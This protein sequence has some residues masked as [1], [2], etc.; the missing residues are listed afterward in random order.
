[1]VKETGIDEAAELPVCCGAAS[2]MISW[3]EPI[4]AVT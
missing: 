1:M 3:N 4:A 2:M